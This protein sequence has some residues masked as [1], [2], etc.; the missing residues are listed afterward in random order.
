MRIPAKPHAVEAYTGRVAPPRGWTLRFPDPELERAYRGA[1]RDQSVRRARTASLVAILVWVT[2]AIVGPPALG[3]ARGPAVAICGFMTIFLLACAAAS[4]W[5]DVV[6]L[7]QQVVATVAALLLT[8]VTDH[9]ATY[10]MP[11]I[12]LTAVFGFSVTRPP[13]AGA[14]V[15]G[16]FYCVAFAVVAARHLD[17]GEFLFQML[18]VVFT[19]ATASVGAYLL[20]RSQRE[21]FTQGL[22]IRDLHARVDALLRQYLSP[23][24]A[25]T[26]IEHP[27]RS[28]LGGEEVD[29]TVLFADLGGFTAFAERVTPAEVVAMLN[30]T[31]GAAVPIVLAEGG[32][33]V[34][35]MGDAMLAVFNAPAPYPDHPLRAARAAL[36]IQ[37]A[38]KELAAAGD[39][40]RFRV[41]ITTGPALVGNI[42][43][44]ELRSF[45]AIGDTT[46][47]AARLQA[48]A[49]EGSV[50]IAEGTYDRIR[51][52]A[53]VRELGAQALKGKSEPVRVFELVALGANVNS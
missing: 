24:V 20:E 6:G 40:P 10:A 3:V 2:I 26:L 35:F 52:R 30:A 1:D 43:G 46:N 8:S 41:G 17:A 29:V 33:V 34:Q 7:G 38:M 37:A 19:V 13:F 14:V 42:G 47:L 15:L 27:E 25:A 51:D 45:V 32:T 48:F 21:T 23:E 31:Y 11:A 53:V 36:A 28:S 5:A 18:I 50:V 9:V 4:R 16:A 44:G 49:P 22:V 12:M 39:R